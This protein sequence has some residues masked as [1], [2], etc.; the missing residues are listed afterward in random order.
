VTPPPGRATPALVVGLVVALLGVVGCTDQPQPHRETTA[1]TR[2]PGPG[3]PT[4]AGTNLADV[5]GLEPVRAWFAAGQ[6]APRL[7]LA[8]SPT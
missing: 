1:V 6:G 3:Q 8:L 7:V 2:T 4:Q 5:A